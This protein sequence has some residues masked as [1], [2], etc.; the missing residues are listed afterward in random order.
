MKNYLLLISM[1]LINGVLFSQ[2]IRTF[3]F[4]KVVRYVDSL[5]CNNKIIW[6]KS[7]DTIIFETKNRDI[8]IEKNIEEYTFLR[9]DTTKLKDTVIKEEWISNLCIGKVSL[10]NSNKDIKE[11]LKD[12]LIIS[13]NQTIVRDSTGQY[14]DLWIIIDGYIENMEDGE[15]WGYL[16]DNNVR[17]LLYIKDNNIVG[18]KIESWTS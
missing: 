10:I 12:K 15:I 1:L 4:E 11:K 17:V 2:D 13:F 3:E 9:E 16:Y 5:L 6:K 14:L 18:Y 8:Y 7:G